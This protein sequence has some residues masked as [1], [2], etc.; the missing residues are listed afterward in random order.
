VCNSYV[1]QMLAGQKLAVTDVVLVLSQCCVTGS[2]L[3]HEDNCDRSTAAN[4]GIML[5][6][7]MMLMHEQ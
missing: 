3:H 6:R 7:H 2:Y 1:D 4:A 5:V